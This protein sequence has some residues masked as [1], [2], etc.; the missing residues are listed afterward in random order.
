MNKLILAGILLTLGFTVSCTRGVSNLERGMMMS[1]NIYKDIAPQVA[2]ALESSAT[3]STRDKRLRVINQKLDQ[4]KIAY[5][6]CAKAIGKWKS[7]GEAPENTMDIYKGMWQSLIDA[8]TLAASIYIYA[9]ECTARTAIKGKAGD[10][11]L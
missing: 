10:T 9:S 11:C 7:T 5:N 1:S 8:Q 3:D 2:T 4:Y 6:E